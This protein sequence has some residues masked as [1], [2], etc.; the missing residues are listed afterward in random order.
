MPTINA[1][2]GSVVPCRLDAGAGHAGMIPAPEGADAG[3]VQLIPTCDSRNA[4]AGHAGMIPAPEGTDA[5]R[6]QLTAS[7]SMAGVI[8]RRL[9][10]DGRGAR[11]AGSV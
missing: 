2:P 10:E 1:S 9:E 4:G 3:R 5:A 8:P 7:G 11:P 6:V